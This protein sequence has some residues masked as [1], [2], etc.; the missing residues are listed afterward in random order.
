[1]QLPG[2]LLRRGARVR[3][4]RLKPPTGHLELAIAEGSPGDLTRRVSEVLA[5]ALHDVAGEPATV[6]LVEELCVSDRQFLMLSVAR[7]LGHRHLW[8]TVTC[9]ACGEAMDIPIDLAAL[10][11]REAAEGFPFARVE[12]SLGAVTVRAP[13]GADQAA[14]AGV[15]DVDHAVRALLARCLPDGV[16][17]DA[18]TDGDVAAIEEALEEVSPAIALRVQAAC[19]ECGAEQILD[20]D[21]YHVARE[22]GARVLDAVHTLAAFY[23]WSEE[24]ILALPLARRELYL[25]R[26]DRARGMTS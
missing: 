11:V 5:M 1:M 13:T 7:L 19:P 4:A 6:A 26:V 3:D 16:T 9:D 15:A 20:I 22:P 17:P 23:H 8:R 25:A 21:P 2:G 14:V 18:L 24:A 12:T 10:P